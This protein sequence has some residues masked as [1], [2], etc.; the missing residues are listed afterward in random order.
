MEVYRSRDMSHFYIWKDTDAKI[1]NRINLA[2]STVYPRVLNRAHYD[3]SYLKKEYIKVTKKDL[4]SAVIH[5]FT[6]KFPIQSIISTK[7]EKRLVVKE[8]RCNIAQNEIRIYA[9]TDKPLSSLLWS[10]NAPADMP[11]LIEEDSKKT[12]ASGLYQDKHIPNRFYFVKSDGVC[13]WI[14]VESCGI[15]SWND[16]MPPDKDVQ[17][18]SL[19]KLE[20]EI[21]KVFAKNYPDKC[22]VYSD[23]LAKNVQI[24]IAKLSISIVTYARDLQI[25]IS[26]TQLSPTFWKIKIGPKNLFKEFPKTVKEKIEWGVYTNKN[27]NCFYLV[28]IDSEAKY[29]KVLSDELRVATIN[30]AELDNKTLIKSCREDLE[31]YIANEFSALYPVNT[32]IIT[33]DQEQYCRDATENFKCYGGINYNSLHIILEVK[34]LSRNPT[35][36]PKEIWEYDSVGGKEV[37]LPTI[38]TNQNSS[39][40]ITQCKQEFDFLMDPKGI[41]T[42]P[43]S[44]IICGP[45]PRYPD[46]FE[47]EEMKKALEEDEPVLKSELRL[48]T[49][50]TGSLKYYQGRQKPIKNRITNY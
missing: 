32:Q 36:S 44:E 10:S 42:N 25:K 1:F 35:N 29:I 12:A 4:E 31:E 41:I 37:A 49:K 11:E 27:K 38:I 40:T 43:C 47:V 18:V 48:E 2:S 15:T 34:L 33:A 16:L 3:E 8:L 14:K 26:S 46:P 7:R 5:Y 22:I 20:E 19:L 39:A 21:R 13:I 24:K 28:G 45:P 9:T 6:R 23:Y 50:T 17:C 30:I